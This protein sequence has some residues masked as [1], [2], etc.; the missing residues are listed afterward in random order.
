[1][2]T[3]I[4]PKDGSMTG[5]NTETCRVNPVSRML[6]HCGEHVFKDPMGRTIK[7]LYGKDDQ[8]Q[9]WEVLWSHQ[10]KLEQVKHLPWNATNQISF[11]DNGSIVSE[12]YS[13]YLRTYIKIKNTLRHWVW[14]WTPQGFARK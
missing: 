7:R 14:Y 6:I 9:V 12:E 8:G 4:V 1:M 5:Y 10:Y 2:F 3:M 11:D 13:F